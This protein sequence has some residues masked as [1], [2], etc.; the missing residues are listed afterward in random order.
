MPGTE[1]HESRLEDRSFLA[2]VAIVTLLFCWLIAPYFGAILWGL[3]AAIL[4]E[5]ATQRLAADMNGRKNVAAAL[6][7]LLIVGLILVPALLLGS[8]LVQEA[9]SLYERIR[10]GQIDVPGIMDGI[11]HSLPLR[12]Q[13]Y[14]DRQNLSD[15]DSVRRMFGTGIASGLQTVAS[16]ALVVGQGALSFLAALGVMLYLTFFLLRD[17]RRY[18]S[19]IRSALPLRPDLR[20]RLIDHFII[21]VRATMKGTVVVAVVQGALGGLIFWALG[22]EG[23]LLWGTL[24]GVFSLLPAVGTAI[25]WVPVAIYLL[26]T[27]AWIKGTILI[28]CG[29]FI[30]GLVDNLLRPILVGRDTRMPDFVVLIATLAG[31]QLFGLSGFIVGP[32]IAALFIAVWSMA[33]ESKDHHEPDLLPPPKTVTVLP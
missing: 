31:L 10:L 3:V 27:G 23:A 24:M 6:V 25:I 8:S 5:P 1:P 4:F 21:V 13:Q 30:I 17:G 26:A 2:V 9:T 28:F 33:I 11:K 32:V 22:V 19:I 14:I 15:F 29:F 12:V 18:G 7:L 20:D 16:R